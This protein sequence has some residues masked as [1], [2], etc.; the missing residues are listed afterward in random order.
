M[1]GQLNSKIHA[2]LQH[3]DQQALE[4]RAAVANALQVFIDEL[5]QSQ[6]ILR[7]GY[8]L[9]VIESIKQLKASNDEGNSL[10]KAAKQIMDV[11]KACLKQLQQTQK[12][13]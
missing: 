10:T 3:R 7:G 5:E 12:T 2:L 13:L 6:K 9:K 4:H 11:F 1:I 8:L